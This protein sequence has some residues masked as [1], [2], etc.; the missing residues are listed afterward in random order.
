MS[1]SQVDSTACLLCFVP[2]PSP[3]GFLMQ[4]MCFVLLSA[5]A[6]FKARLAKCMFCPAWQLTTATAPAFFTSAVSSV[7]HVITSYSN[8]E[9]L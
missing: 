4:T 9:T 7:H 3:E 2:A 5:C 8:C 1:A 6:A